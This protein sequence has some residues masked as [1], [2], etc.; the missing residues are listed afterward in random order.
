MHLITKQCPKYDW[1]VAE[2]AN[3]SGISSLVSMSLALSLTLTEL[4][5]SEEGDVNKEVS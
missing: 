3:S 4:T 1:S 2:R 5:G